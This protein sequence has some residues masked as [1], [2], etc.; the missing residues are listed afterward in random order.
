M[1]RLQNIP[2]IPKGFS[3]FL[4]HIQL[5]PD[6]VSWISWGQLYITKTSRSRGSWSWRGTRATSRR[7]RAPR[8][9]LI[10]SSEWRDEADLDNETLPNHHQMHGTHAGCSTSEKEA[11]ERFLENSNHQF[12]DEIDLTSSTNHENPHAPMLLGIGTMLLPLGCLN[13]IAIRTNS[14]TNPWGICVWN[15]N[16][17]QI[18]DNSSSNTIVL[19]GVKSN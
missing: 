3:C 6:S 7:K 19:V 8:N 13:P 11:Q 18:Y 4:S 17:Q 14:E 1:L 2:S 10:L 9:A 5:K 15:N 12:R 16:V